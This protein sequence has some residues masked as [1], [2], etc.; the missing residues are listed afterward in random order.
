MQ[1]KGF[2]LTMDDSRKVDKLLA[3]WIEDFLSLSLHIWFVPRKP[4]GKI[5]L[6]LD[7]HSTLRNSVEILEYAE[8]NYIVF[9][10]AS[11]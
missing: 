4:A 5:L 2:P 10:R 3:S 6:L 11:K 8:E 7:G 1:S 9:R